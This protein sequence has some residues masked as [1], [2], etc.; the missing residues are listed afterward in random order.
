MTRWQQFYL[1]D[2]R[3]LAAPPSLCAQAAVQLF[4][5]EGERTVLD[6]AC[7]VRSQH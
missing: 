5:G 7:G 2:E 3:V 1:E 6:L 4:Q